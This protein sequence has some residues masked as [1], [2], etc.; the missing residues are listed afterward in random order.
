MSLKIRLKEIVKLKTPLP[1]KQGLKHEFEAEH[2]LFAVLKTPLPEKQG[3]KRKYIVANLLKVVP[4]KTPLPE[5][6]GLKHGAAWE[7]LPY[8][9]TLKPHFQK[10][11]D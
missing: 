9:I 10:N 6:Q 7:L 11:K 3:L 8:K 1:E 4:L 5:K 2:G